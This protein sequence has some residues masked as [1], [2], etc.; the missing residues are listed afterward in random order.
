MR[1]WTHANRLGSRAWSVNTC[2]QDC[3]YAK[4]LWL[5][6][7][8]KE[9]PACTRGS[10]WV[11]FSKGV[12]LAESMSLDDAK[13]PALVLTSVTV[14]KSVS[15]SVKCWHS[16]TTLE[17]MRLHVNTPEHNKFS[18]N[19]SHYHV[20]ISVQRLEICSSW[21]FQTFMCV[22]FKITPNFRAATLLLWRAWLL[23]F[24]K[25]GLKLQSEKQKVRFPTTLRG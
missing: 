5:E 1:L 8:K 17:G 13:I 12:V 10:R 16:I 9:E 20:I 23:S 14:G 24:I 4:T 22:Y 15:L 6:I 25:A 3:S 11:G 2:A 21:S 18:I 19:G 7:G